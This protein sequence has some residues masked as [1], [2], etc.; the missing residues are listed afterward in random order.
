M[1]YLFT[2]LYSYIFVQKQTPSTAAKQIDN[3]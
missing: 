3:L 1:Q 2:V